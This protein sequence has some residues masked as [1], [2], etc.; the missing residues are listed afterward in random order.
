[1]FTKIKIDF[2][3]LSKEK[4]SDEKRRKKDPKMNFSCK[5]RVRYSL[6]C[7]VSPYKKKSV[8]GIF[9]VTLIIAIIFKL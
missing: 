6:A 1:M 8:I 5:C 7:H 2:V 9:P 3:K 4:V